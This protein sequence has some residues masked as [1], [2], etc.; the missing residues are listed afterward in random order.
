M[1][2]YESLAH[3]FI[4]DIKS[5]K[6][7]VGTRLPALRTL[8]K[9]HQVS[10]TTATKTYDYLQQTGWIYAQPQSG[11]FVSSDA[12]TH[13]S[14]TPNTH[15]ALHRIEQRDP[16]EFAPEKGYNPS[17]GL[18]TPLGTSMIAP[19]LQPTEELQRAIKR[20]TRRAGKQLFSYPEP[21]G[22]NSLR[23]ALAQH[24]QKDR[25]AFLAKELVITNGCIDAVRIAIQALTKEGDTIAI[26]S[27][28]FSGLL[29][30]LVGM[31]RNVIEIPVQ[32]TGID[33]DYFESVLQQ[34]AVSAS[35]FSTSN[36]NPIGNSLP[37]QQKQALAHLSAKYKVP[38]IEDDIYFEL[39]HHQQ[40]TLP[41]KHWDT[42]GYVVWCGSVSKTLAAGLRLGWC[43][44]G[45]FYNAYLHQQ[46]A[47]GFGVNPLIQSALAEFIN[48]GEYRR[49]VNKMRLKLTQ[50]VHEYRQFMFQHLP[51]NSK[52]SLPQGGMVLWIQV[53]HL[54]STQLEKQALVKNI[55]IRSGACFSTHTFYHDCFRINCGWP[56]QVQGDTSQVQQQ[57]LALCDMV[58][59]LIKNEV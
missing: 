5:H 15:I 54:D 19:Q 48:T 57:L 1:T 52:I 3:Q 59:A 33:L 30:L 6:L 13:T 2:L 32:P 35:L 4:D 56:L 43:L 11:Y 17:S 41:A 42:Q 31:S 44:P 20:A 46:L 9:Q 28:C 38:M 58:K 40:A 47:T 10:L 51:A 18:F 7:A 36:I 29:D 22:E 53:P 39:S 45:R 34:K 49:H 16:K 55:E 12:S 24:F 23:H 25:F 21:E 50:Q 8:A 37:V 26:A 14:P 27:P